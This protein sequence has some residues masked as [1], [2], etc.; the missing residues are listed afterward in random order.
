M[1]WRRKWI[2]YTRGGVDVWLFWRRVS[3]Q[4]LDAMHT[5]SPTAPG[6]G[7]WISRLQRHGVYFSAP[8]D[9]DFL[10]LQH[11]SDA[12]QALDDGELGPHVP[13]KD[14]DL[15]GHE[16][17]IQRAARVVLGDEGG[18]GDTYTAEERE[19]FPWYTY[20]FLGKGKPST[21][22]LALGRLTQDE[23]RTGLPP[24]FA[25]MFTRIREVLHLPEPAEET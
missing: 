1:N 21:H 4:Q 15:D 6:Q 3:Q 14:D 8:L 9:V 18:E 22:I 5:R 17:R 11:F 23:L 25:T 7:F 19:L 2:D 20:R 13:D 16:K 12:Y 24:V 10:M